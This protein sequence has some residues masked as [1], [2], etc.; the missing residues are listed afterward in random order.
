M[1]K[2]TIVQARYKDGVFRPLKKLNLPDDSVVEII[3]DPEGAQKRL[4]ALF[5]KMRAR[6]AHIP[7]EEIERDIE[8]AIREVREERRK[9]LK[10]AG[11]SR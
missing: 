3:I 5:K 1:R 10:T 6:N 11:R 8:Q 7:P 2:K 4:E 9:S